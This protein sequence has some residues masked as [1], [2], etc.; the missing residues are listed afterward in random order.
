V[1]LEVYGENFPLG[2]LREAPAKAKL[3]VE[4]T[5]PLHKIFVAVTTNDNKSRVIGTTT[6]LLEAKF[7][8]GGGKV[9]HIEDVSVKARYQRKGI[10]FIL[11]T[12]A[13]ALMGPYY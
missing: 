8:F 2:Q 11:V 13:T 5:I 10:G 7:I 4:N 12:H 6:L 9:E 3:K 1:D